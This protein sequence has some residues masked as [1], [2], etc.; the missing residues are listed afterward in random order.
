V[1]TNEHD[2]SGSVV[3]YLYQTSWALLELISQKRADASLTLEMLDDVVW[4]AD[5]SPTELIQVKHHSAPGGLG[6]MSVDLWR[7]I[8]VWLDNGSPKDSLGPTLTLV[9]TSIATPGTAAFFLRPGPERDPDRALS[10]LENAATTSQ[11]ADTESWRAK[12]RDLSPVDRKTVV[13][14]IFVS[15][16][17]HSIEEIESAIRNELWKA[18]PRGDGAKEAFLA[19]LS[20]WWNA[21][22]IDLLRGKRG[23]ISRD[24]IQEAI[25]SIRDRFSD[26]S[27]P[28]L[29]ELEDVDEE[30][31]YELN[32]E[33]TFVHQLNWIQVHADNLRTAIVDYHR[34]VSQETSWLDKDLVDISELQIFEARLVDEWRRVFADMLE[35]LGADADEAAKVQR[36]RELFRQLRDSAIVTIRA[37]YQDA[38]FARG[39]RHDL[40]DRSE[41]GWHPE[42]EQRLAA[43]VGV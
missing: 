8:N 39:K 34:A 17:S 6:N 19:L 13:A 21:V 11:S 29:V 36:G 43:L 24:Q 31:A 1:A 15:D 33:R 37:Q 5:G 12:F 14:R 3:G 38:F 22:S 7:T 41:L 2:A 18:M 20:R 16:G 10:I 30:A 42:F 26:D 35:D 25:A 23:A 32:S 9:T 40:A 27:L 4:E 28:T